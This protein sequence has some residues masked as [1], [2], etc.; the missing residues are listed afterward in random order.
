MNPT[1]S[2]ITPANLVTS[3]RLLLVPVLT[4]LARHRMLIPFAILFPLGV[5]TDGVDGWVAR[6][7]GGAGD[8]GRRFDSSVDACFYYPVLLWFWW[9]R[10]DAVRAWWPWIVA[11]VGLLLAGVAVKI[12]KR[13]FIAALHL[14]TTRVAGAAAM[15]YLTWIMW[16]DV[17][18]VA[19]YPVWGLLV[20]AA[21]V[22]LKAA[23]A[24][25][26]ADGSR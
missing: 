4:L 21:W 15:L 20:A 3:L 24:L 2:W 19:F 22:E 12:L 10:P 18:A 5:A 23:L 11:P 7:A 14:P 13:R 6:R 8:T 9:L 16:S 26:T 25:R 17:P 1:I